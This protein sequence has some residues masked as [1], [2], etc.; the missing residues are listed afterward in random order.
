METEERVAVEE[1]RGMLNRKISV[2][3]CPPLMPLSNQ[4]LIKGYK[5]YKSP[6]TYTQV[7]LFKTCHLSIQWLFKQ[8][9]G[10]SKAQLYS[11]RCGGGGP[12]RAKFFEQERHCMYQDCRWPDKHTLFLRYGSI[13]LLRLQGRRS[14]F[15]MRLAWPNLK[16]APVT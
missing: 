6:S 11:I 16:R 1:V 10:P 12:L 13:L 8:L 5:Q 9:F 7:C 2:R 15:S 14:R 4:E 3:F